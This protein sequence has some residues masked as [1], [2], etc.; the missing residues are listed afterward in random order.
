MEA[1]ATQIKIINQAYNHH[2]IINL[3]NFESRFS[4]INRK[5]ALIKRI[6][7]Y[8][9]VCSVIAPLYWIFSFPSGHIKEKP[10]NKYLIFDNFFTE[11]KDLL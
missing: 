5:Q 10:W 3:K 7:D 6:D 4:K 2:D 8:E 11:N 9:R 1:K